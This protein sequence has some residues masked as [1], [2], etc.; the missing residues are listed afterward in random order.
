MNW[1]SD[2]Y[3]D[4]RFKIEDAIHDWKFDKQMNKWDKE[5]LVQ[6]SEDAFV[7]EVKPKKK[8]SKKSKKT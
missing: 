4:I 2:L 3:W 5:D 1:L 6:D 7:E 8:K